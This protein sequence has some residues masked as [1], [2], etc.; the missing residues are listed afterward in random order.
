M[1]FYLL[2]RLLFYAVPITAKNRC[3]LWLV[4]DRAIQYQVKYNQQQAPPVEGVLG[5]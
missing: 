3:S 4:I 2:R 5:G 1:G